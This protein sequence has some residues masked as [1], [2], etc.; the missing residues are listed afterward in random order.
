MGSIIDWDAVNRSTES[1]YYREWRAVQLY[2]RGLLRGWVWHLRPSLAE[3]AGYQD[4]TLCGI[5]L[6]MNEG[7]KTFCGG[8]PKAGPREW[9]KAC[10]K[11]RRMAEVSDGT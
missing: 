1:A 10:R 9:L 3:G 5:A 11:C 4:V 8:V 2:H 7:G 6:D